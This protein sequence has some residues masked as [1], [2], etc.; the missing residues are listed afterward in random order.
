[1]DTFA[2]IIHPIDPK[3]DVSR[4]YPLLGRALTEQ[5]D[6]FLLDL[7]PAGVYLRDRRASPPLATGK[8][9]QAAGLWPAR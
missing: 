3:R 6:Q 2:F 9:I 5:Q 4:K 7:L 8:E 1:M